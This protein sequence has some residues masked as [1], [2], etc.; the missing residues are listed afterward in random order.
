MGDEERPK[1]AQEHTGTAHLG[2]G[3]HED[4]AL[5]VQPQEAGAGQGQLAHSKHHVDGVAKERQLAHGLWGRRGEPGVLVTGALGQGRRQSFP[6]PCTPM[7]S[8][9]CLP[10]APAPAAPLPQT[11]R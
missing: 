10:P 9:L 8:L 6:S 2:A 7:P 11:H 3:V 1:S 5:T 4:E